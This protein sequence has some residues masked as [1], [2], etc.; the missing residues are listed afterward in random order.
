[1]QVFVTG[2]TGFIGS[3]VVKELIGAG[4]GVTG[5][6]RTDAGAAKLSA[7]GAQVHRGDLDDFAALKAGAAAADGVAHLAFTHTFPG[8]LRAPAK[9]AKVIAALGS[10]LEGTGKPLVVAGAVLGVRT[11]EVLTE[12]YVPDYSKVPRKSEQAVLAW[13]NRGVRAAVIRLPP[14]VHGAGDK[15]FVP[16]LIARARKNGCAVFV[17]DGR[18]RWAAVHRL[19]AASLFRLALEKGIAGGIYQGVGDEGV[20]FGD[21]AAA[22]GRGVSV[23]AVS[24]SSLGAV[25]SLGFLGMLARIDGPASSARTR[26]ALGWAPSQSGLLDDL[27]SGGYFTALSA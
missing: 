24:R 11:G 25:W 1:M 10:A 12:D 17:G 27:V 23:P 19:D 3:A 26:E 9:D 15:A 13:A 22:I 6:A 20:A 5:L 7:A 16:S 21:L 2:A 8:V 4:H 14:S 18:A